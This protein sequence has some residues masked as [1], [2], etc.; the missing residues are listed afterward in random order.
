MVNE[1]SHAYQRPSRLEYLLNRAVGALV[2]LG[3][4]P[5]HM[6]VLEVRGR[7]SGKLYALPVDLLAEQG[8]LYLVAPRGYTQ[9]VRNAEASG[10]ITLRRGGRAEGYRLRV[11]SD[12]EKPPILKAYL[13]RFRREV[14]RYFPVPAGSPVE[15][16]SPLA[17]RYPAYELLSRAATAPNPEDQ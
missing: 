8:K 13:D 17:P 9:W 12:T 3:I 15:R 2:R 6:R 1:P 14:Q 4:G 5:A 10:D 16:F 11:L 7:T